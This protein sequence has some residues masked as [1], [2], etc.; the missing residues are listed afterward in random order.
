MVKLEL[1][2]TAGHSKDEFTELGKALLK[3]FSSDN[4]ALTCE[5]FN[6]SNRRLNSGCNDSSSSNTARNLCNGEMTAKDNIT[7]Y[8]IYKRA[9]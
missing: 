7:K 4:G 3:P 1:L 8:Q 9:N 6:L 2:L 5:S